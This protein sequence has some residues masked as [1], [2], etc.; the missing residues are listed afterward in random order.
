[1]STP[2]DAAVELARRSGTDRHD[3]AVV[4]GSGWAA[5]ADALGAA[6]WE[7]PVV[8]LPGFPG[9]T[10]LGHGGIIG[11]AMEGNKLRFV[12]DAAA[13]DRAHLRVSAQLLKL[14][15]RVVKDEP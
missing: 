3:V 14:A 6:S 7:E 15:M 10:A 13:A 11:F 9:P 2:A 8:R 12:I 1:M 4:L 5:A